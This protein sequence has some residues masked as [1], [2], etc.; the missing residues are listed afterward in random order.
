MF[1]YFI[2][3]AVELSMLIGYILVLSLLIGIFL[4]VIERPAL[5]RTLLL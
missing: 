5:E 3:V 2:F 1:T 4:D